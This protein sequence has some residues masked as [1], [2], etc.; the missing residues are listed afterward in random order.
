[1]D[2]G[3]GIILP[4]EGEELEIKKTNILKLKK[5]NSE[6]DV[7][8]SNPPY[9]EL[10]EKKIMSKNVLGYEPHEAIFVTYDD[11]L[12]YY[13]KIIFLA[14]QMIKISGLSVRN[15]KNP[16]GDIEIKFTGKRPGEKLFEELLIDD[17][18]MQKTNH[19]KIMRAKE[20][21]IGEKELNQLCYKN[22]NI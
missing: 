14:E 19:P 10:N 1:M 6:Y 21:Y 15:D 13:K 8:V 9:I 20:S 12:V 5:L 22:I 7:I 16:N 4:A 11:P 2:K 3:L 18:K 17:T